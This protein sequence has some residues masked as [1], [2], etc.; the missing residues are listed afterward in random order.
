MDTGFCRTQHFLSEHPKVTDCIPQLVFSFYPHRPIHADFSG[1]QI[2]S[3]AG[4]LPLRAFDHRHG[5]TRELVERLSDPREDERIHVRLLSLTPPASTP[6]QSIFRVRV[7]LSLK[8]SLTSFTS[9]FLSPAS[10]P[11][12][13]PSSKSHVCSFPRS[14]WERL[15]QGSRPTRT[16]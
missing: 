1:G 11:R 4:L 16:D 12:A 14:I 6:S 15:P 8:S 3:D 13:I 2:S 7:R 5:L 10:R 9:P